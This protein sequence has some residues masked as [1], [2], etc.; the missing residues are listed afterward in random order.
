MLLHG[1][2]DDGSCWVG[3]VPVF[4]ARGYRVVAPDARAHGLTPLLADDDFTAAARTQDAVAAMEALDIEGALVVGHSMGAITAMQLAARHRQLTRAIV[5]IDPP[6]RDVEPTERRNRI[7]QFEAWVAEVASMSSDALAGVCRREN[8]AWT[9]SEI[10][11]WVASKRAVDQDLFRRT[12][13]WHEGSWRATMDA[14]R[15]PVLLIAGEPHLGSLV[16]ERAGRWLDEHP[17]IRFV[18]VEGAGHSVHRD[19]A[20]AFAGVVEGFLDDR[21]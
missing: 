18:R 17:G 8:P 20:E 7:D 5:L 6:L 13:S 19:A 15:V 10:E 3:T 21:A 12:Q 11:T 1:F 16:E 14:I 9:V 4:N 2:S